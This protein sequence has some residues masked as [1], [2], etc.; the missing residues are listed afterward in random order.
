LFGF[1]EDEKELNTSGI[2]LGLV[3]SKNIVN[4]YGGDITVQSEFGHGSTFTFSFSL[5]SE[6]AELENS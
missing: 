5:V 6:P 2:G 4:Q 1:L 3:I